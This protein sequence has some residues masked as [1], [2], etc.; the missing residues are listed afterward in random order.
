MNQAAHL[1]L[2]QKLDTQ[3]DQIQARVAEIDRLLSEDERIQAAR[4]ATDTAHRNLENARLEARNAD[5]L[6]SDQKVKIEQSEASLYGGKIHNP[7]ELQDLQR[8]IESLKRHLATLEDRQLETMIALEETEQVA[9]TVDGTLEKTQAEVI[10][11]K[12]GLAGERERLLKTRQRLETERSVALS[13][14]LEANLQIY[15]RIREQRKGIAVA[16]ID[17]ETC[18]TCGA[19]IRPAEAQA[20]RLQSALH[21]CSSCGR[22]LFAG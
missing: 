22:V 10:Q 20:A 6:V 9:S 8:E 1:Y 12:A 17:D 15:N 16:C 14:I 19:P 21:Y 7:K 5:H 13:P 18:S 2:L 3:L 11:A 4:Q